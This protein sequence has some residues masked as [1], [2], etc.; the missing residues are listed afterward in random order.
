MGKGVLKAVLTYCGE[1][2]TT[3]NLESSATK[4][5]EG[6]SSSTSAINIV[7]GDFVLVMLDVIGKTSTTKKYFVVVLDFDGEHDSVILKYMHPRRSSWIW[8]KNDDISMDKTSVILQK[9]ENPKVINNR[10]QF[11]FV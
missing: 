6:T 10:G 11:V 2:S 8:S 5:V 1:I 3:V 9:V 4:C 7:T